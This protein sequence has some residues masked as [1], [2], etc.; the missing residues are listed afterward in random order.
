MG[1]LLDKGDFLWYLY[2]VIK[3]QTAMK[4]IVIKTFRIYGEVCTMQH[5]LNSL[6]DLL[7]YLRM[8][9]SDKNNVSIN[10]IF[11]NEL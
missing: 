4:Y 9:G 11:K 8:C 7:S 5:T 3:K 10:I 1:Y 2:S 6:E